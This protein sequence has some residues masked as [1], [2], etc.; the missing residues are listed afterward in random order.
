[1]RLEMLPS[2][3]FLEEFD[4]WHSFLF[5]YLVEFIRETIWSWDFPC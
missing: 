1:M 3:Q 5:N 4:D 2:L